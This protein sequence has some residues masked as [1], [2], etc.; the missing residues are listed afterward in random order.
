MTHEDERPSV[1]Q[2]LAI[3]LAFV[4][5]FAWTLV[6]AFG[7][8][9]A[10]DPLAPLMALLAV[11]GAAVAGLTAAFGVLMLLGNLSGD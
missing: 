3:A 4:V 8:I 5:V 2:G 11:A 9:H 7:G 1:W 6:D 10:G